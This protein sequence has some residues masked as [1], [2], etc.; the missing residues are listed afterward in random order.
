MAYVKRCPFCHGEINS[1]DSRCPVCGAALSHHSAGTSGFESRNRDELPPL[2][3]D[4][5]TSRG[6]YSPTSKC[7]Y[8]GGFV[9]ADEKNC[10]GCG[11]SNEFYNPEAGAPA[12]AS[13]AAGDSSLPP[14]TIEELKAFC[15]ARGMPLFRMRFFIGR[16]YREPKAFGIYRD[17]EN[18]VVYKNKADGS[19][20]IRYQGP[21]E[22]RGVNELYQKLLVECHNRGIYPERQAPGSIPS[23]SSDTRSLPES[24]GSEHRGRQKSSSAAWVPIVITLLAYLLAMRLFSSC[25]G[26]TIHFSS[27]GGSYSS[28]YSSSN[29]D[30]DDDDWDWDS[31]DTDWDPDW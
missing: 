27:G 28:S 3:I 13:P 7:P 21:D 9:R 20:A 26:G 2:K 23:S 22:A 18:V 4:P 6:S 19:R 10:P 24:G 8:C 30:D 1:E 16:D 5:P 17:G 31:D 12:K 25:G 15:E 14:Q 29:W 11:A